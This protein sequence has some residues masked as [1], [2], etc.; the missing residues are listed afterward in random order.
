MDLYFGGTEQG[1][2]RDLLYAEGVRHMSLSFMG[3]RRRVKR[4]DRWLLDQKY[5]EDVLIYLDPGTFTLNKPGSQ[6]TAAEAETLEHEYRTFVEANLHRLEF[7]AEFDAAVLGH[8]AIFS[9]REE[10]WANLPER[11]WMP[12]WHSDYGTSNL[13]ALGDEFGRVGVLQDD[14]SGDLTLALNRMA[15]QTRLHGVSLTRIDAIMAVDWASAGSTRWLAPTQYGD[16]IVWTGHELKDYPKAYK[17]TGRKRH[18]TWLAENGFDTEKIEADDNRELLR[19][20][21]WSWQR[22]IDHRQPVAVTASADVPPGENLEHPR[23]PV[24]T[25]GSD[26]GNEERSIASRTPAVP[27]ERTLLP[28]VGFDFETIRETG[29]DGQPTE[30]QESR[31]VT[32]ATSL[33]QCDTCFMK[34]KCPAMEAGSACKYE[35][36]VQVRTPA[37][38]DSVMAA[39][40]EMQTQRVLRMTMIE[41][42]EG[43]YADENLSREMKRLWEMMKDRQSGKDTVKLTLEAGGSAASAGMISRIFGENAGSR[44]AALEA[45]RDTQDV[46]GQVFEAEVVD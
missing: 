17:E 5:P 29:E 25:P 11:K 12:V 14:A 45:P 3:L 10:F 34:A 41:Q 19:L 8:D 2:W 27:A 32:P 42:T 39:L 18:R 26:A 33:L 46:V 20:S 38:I 4:L 44:L 22:F 15:G 43:G 30:R 21:V 6:I 24:A 23:P 36:P 40:V 16:T 1:A 28:V 13:I 37:Q 9:N 7:A 31:M 35:I